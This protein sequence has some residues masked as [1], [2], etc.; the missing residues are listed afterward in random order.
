MLQEGG[1]LTSMGIASTDLPALARQD[2]R[3]EAGEITQFFLKCYRDPSGQ[4]L[5]N[6][7]HD[8]GAQSC[9][10]HH[11]RSCVLCT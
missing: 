7:L 8:P 2:R 5:A 4:E 9:A 11:Q 1:G 6:V 10:Q 3:R